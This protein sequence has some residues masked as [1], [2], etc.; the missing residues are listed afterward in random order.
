MLRKIL[1]A[2]NKATSDIQKT[3]FCIGFQGNPFNSRTPANQQTSITDRGKNHSRGVGRTVNESA[4]GSNKMQK[5]NFS[6][7]NPAGS[8]FRTMNQ[9]YYRW[10]QPRGDR[11]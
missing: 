1:Q 8:D 2:I 6:L 4:L 7:G 11:N 10:I 5:E 3:S 9:A